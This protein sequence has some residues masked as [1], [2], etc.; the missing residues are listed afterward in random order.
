MQAKFR[1][2]LLEY[3]NFRKEHNELLKKNIELAR[4]ENRQD[5]WESQ[6]EDD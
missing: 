2:F 5:R 3:K 6:G 1:K 4:V